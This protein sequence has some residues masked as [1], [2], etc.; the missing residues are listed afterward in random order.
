MLEMI[1]CLVFCFKRKRALKSMNNVFKWTA[2]SYTHLLLC[3]VQ[4]KMSSVLFEILHLAKC[5]GL[6]HAMYII[7]RC[8]TLEPFRNPGSLFRIHSVRPE[9]SFNALVSTKWDERIAY[10]LLKYKESF[11]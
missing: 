7:H 5:G 4:V 6:Q 8:F 10:C 3:I 9:L 11:K 2:T 1:F